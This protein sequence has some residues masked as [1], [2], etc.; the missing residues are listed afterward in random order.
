MDKN[1][2]I[3]LSVIIATFNS[4]KVLPKVLEALKNQTFPRED[5]EILTVDGMSEDGTRR[6]AEQYGCRV[7]D[8]PK[9]EQGNAKIIGMQNAKGRYILFVDSDEAMNNP[10]GLANT[11]DAL[12]DNPQCHIAVCSGY[13]KPDSYPNLSG[14]ISDFG[15]PFSFFVYNYPKDFR[16]YDQVLRKYYDIVRDEKDYFVFDC[17]LRRHFPLIEG[18]CGGIIMDMEDYDKILPECRTNI[19]KLYH[20]FYYMCECGDTQTIYVKNNPVDHYSS[21]RL[22]GYFRKLKWRI[23]NNVHFTEKG[24]EVFSGRQEFQKNNRWK[25]YLFIPYGISLVIPFLHS[26]PYAVTRKNPVYLMHFIFSFY[27]VVQIAWQ[28]LLKI[29]HIT[30]EF[31]AYGSGKKI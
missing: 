24:Q 2:D 27:V 3:E 8:N 30:P 25:K 18:G 10:Q 23:C 21:D 26:I 11:L 14:Y 4:E 12:R 17:D 9:V 31:R 15:D 20:S 28:M 29:L 16:F 13:K 6:I 1:Y 7:I 5:M 22:K 19:G